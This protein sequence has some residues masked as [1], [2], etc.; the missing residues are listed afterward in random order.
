MVTDRDDGE[1]WIV[2]V[3]VYET[4]SQRRCGYCQWPN[5]G[6][7]LHKDRLQKSKVSGPI[8][9]QKHNHYS[10]KYTYTPIETHTHPWIYIET[11]RC[12]CTSWHRKRTRHKLFW[13]IIGKIIL[14]IYFIRKE[15]RFSKSDLRG[16]SSGRMVTANLAFGYYRCR[17]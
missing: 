11:H 13:A 14:T 12:V 16:L 9:H 4:T 7:P 5:G 10:H 3:W 2:T 15:M 6:G 17:N 8:L 1:L